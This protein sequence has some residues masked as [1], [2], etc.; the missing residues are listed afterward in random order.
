MFKFFGNRMAAAAPT[1]AAPRVINLAVDHD[2]SDYAA[3]QALF[4]DQKAL[5]FIPSTRVYIGDTLSFQS[6]ALGCKGEEPQA[7]A[8]LAAVFGD[9]VVQG[10]GVESFARHIDIPGVEVLNG[11]IEGS[12]LSYTVDRALDLHRRAGLVGVALHPGWQNLIYGERGED[13]WA[14]QLD[15]LEGLPRL[16]HFT[17]VADVN[18]EV[19]AH[20]YQDL[21]R[22]DAQST[23]EDR[24]YVPLAQLDFSAPG[25][26]A[27]FRDAVEGFNTFLRAYCARRG[28]TLIDLT[29]VLAPRGLAEVTERFFDILHPRISMYQ[30]IGAEVARQWACEFDDLAT[31]IKATEPK[32]GPGTAKDQIGLPPTGATYPLW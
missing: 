30:A 31:P 20:G 10:V 1:P 29:G 9:S 6:N 25:E 4:L 8:P 21:F 27:A 15:R 3:Y 5:R 2:W 13:Y 22:A 17:L 23:A 28:R 7:G 16:A 18:D 26:V 24:H 14:A 32:R 12:P 19:L 11:G